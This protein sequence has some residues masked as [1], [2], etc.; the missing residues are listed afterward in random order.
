[1]FVREPVRT[2]PALW[3]VND[4]AGHAILEQRLEFGSTLR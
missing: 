3:R 2:A 4:P 1:M